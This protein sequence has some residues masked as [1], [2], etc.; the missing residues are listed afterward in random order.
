M[1]NE[2]LDYLRTVCCAD[3]RC[4]AFSL[5]SEGGQRSRFWLQMRDQKKE[6]EGAHMQEKTVQ[7]AKA[8]TDI[9]E[10]GGVG[11]RRL[12]LPAR[13]FA[14]VATCQCPGAMHF[15]ILHELLIL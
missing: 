13:R 6:C 12:I 10:W 4:A 3:K 9:E 15:A 11:G 1:T 7:K 5:T 2:V 14:N 8:K